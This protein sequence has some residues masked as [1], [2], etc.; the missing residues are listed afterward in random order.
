M[1]NGTIDETVMIRCTHCK[2]LLHG[3]LCAHTREDLD[4]YTCYKP[5]CIRKSMELETTNRLI[6]D[7]M[8]WTYANTF[9]TAKEF[10]AENEKKKE[11]EEEEEEEKCVKEKEKQNKEKNDEVG[12]PNNAYLTKEEF[13]KYDLNNPSGLVSQFWIE[14]PHIALHMRI[15]YVIS[16]KEGPILYHWHP[17]AFTHCNIYRPQVPKLEANYVALT[18]FNHIDMCREWIGKPTLR[19]YPGFKGKEIDRKYTPIIADAKKS[20][21]KAQSEI[22]LGNERIFVLSKMVNSLKHRKAPMTEI[23]EMIAVWMDKRI[24]SWL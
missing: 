18:M 14:N 3:L 19:R 22:E 2:E 1:T 16:G 4:D 9:K 23:K 15:H 17:S 21:N 11:E 12:H 13:N 10:F 5:E 20:L 24:Q 6:T 7:E 8:E